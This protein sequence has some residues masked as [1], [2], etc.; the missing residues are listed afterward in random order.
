MREEEEE[1]ARGKRP[2]RSCEGAGS[3]RV[4]IEQS[5][6]NGSFELLRQSLRRTCRENGSVEFVMIRRL[7]I[8]LM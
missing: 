5:E 1:R 8:E 2:M 3:E 6:E 4:I 7:R